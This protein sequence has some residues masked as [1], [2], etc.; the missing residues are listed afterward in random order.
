ML[1]SMPFARPGSVLSAVAITSGPAAAASDEGSSDSLRSNASS[2]SLASAAIRLFLAVSA[3]RAQAAARSAEVMF[4]TSVS[5]FSRSAADWSGSRVTG[6]LA[7]PAARAIL[8]AGRSRRV[9][10]RLKRAVDRRRRQGG[11]SVTKIRRIKIILAG[12]AN[13]CE[14]GIATSVGQRSAHALGIGGLGDRTDRPV[15]GDPLAGGVGERGGQMDHPGGLIDRGR[16][17]GGD[18]VL[19]QRLAHDIE[20]TGERRIAE[21]ALAVSRPAGANGSGERLFRIDEFGLGLGQGRGERRDRFTGPGHGSPP[22]PA[23]QSSPPPISNAWLS[24]RARWPPWHP[25][26]SRL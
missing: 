17:K 24:L 23:H 25:P 5:S 16:L 3:S 2:T 15:R 8:I 21:A 13:E 18:L 10:P 11:W 12:D 20:P 26:A 22:S 4:P 19:T 7:L 14:Q 1:L 6:G 9:L